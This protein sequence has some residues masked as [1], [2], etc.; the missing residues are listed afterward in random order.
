MSWLGTLESSLCY[1]YALQPS[2]VCC[3]CNWATQPVNPD[4]TLL[5]FMREAQFAD[6][7]AWI[8]AA[9]YLSQDQY[10]NPMSGHFVQ[11]SVLYNSLF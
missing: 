6:K 7:Q 10:A 8:V 9:A 4:I 5:Q 3:S 11:H 2:Y 1:A